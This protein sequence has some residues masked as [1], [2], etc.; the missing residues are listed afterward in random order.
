MGSDTTEEQNKV[1]SP[2]S[3]LAL[4]RLHGEEPV[5]SRKGALQ[6]SQC[7]LLGWG[8]LIM[9]WWKPLIPTFTLTQWLKTQREEM[10]RH[11][12]VQHWG[13]S[14]IVL[15]QPVAAFTAD[16]SPTGGGTLYSVPLSW[17]QSQMV[18]LKMALTGLGVHW[19]LLTA[20]SQRC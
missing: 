13:S 6:I 15:L 19:H 14:G 17:Q 4:G 9:P 7:R 20:R 12:N 8:E 18:P 3:K 2:P 11:R 1:L 10:W 16:S 5:I